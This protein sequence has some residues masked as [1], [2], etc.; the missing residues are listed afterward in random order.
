MNNRDNLVKAPKSTLVETQR[1]VT[2]MLNDALA[3]VEV[4]SD[5]ICGPYPQ[6]GEDPQKPMAGGI[7]GELMDGFNTHRQLIERIRSAATMI[8]STL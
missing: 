8:R 6:A 3:Q 4:L 5:L 7:A 2:V 1:E